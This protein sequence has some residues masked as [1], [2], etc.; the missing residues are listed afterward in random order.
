MET[1]GKGRRAVCQV[2]YIMWESTQR[3]KCLSPG[4]DE[5][6]PI[7]V[8]HVVLLSYDPHHV[9]T[10]VMIYDN[11]STHSPHSSSCV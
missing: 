6:G 8:V 7:F 11:N 4:W 5:R 2:N 9:T 3:S 10:S 1:E